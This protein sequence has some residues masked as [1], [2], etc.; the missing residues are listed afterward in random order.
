MQ[1]ITDSQLSDSIGQSGLT[2]EGNVNLSAE[3]L[4]YQ[5]RADSSYLIL[6]D[7]QAQFSYSPAT[8]D[9][10]AQGTIRY[11]LPNTLKFD[12]LSLALYSSNSQTLDLNNSDSIQ[13]YTIY[14]SSLGNQHK[15]FEL[16]I[17]GIKL[18]DGSN[19]FEDDYIDTNILEN[20]ASTSFTVN[21]KSDINIELISDDDCCFGNEDYAQITVVDEDG[22]IIQQTGSSGENDANLSLHFDSPI[23]NNFIVQATLTGTFNMGGA[24]EVF[25]ASNVPTKH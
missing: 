17:S 20:N 7:I 5:Q 2:I 22:N 19:Y 6:N 14:A 24:I 12:N 15:G 3:Q 8:V 11:G 10:T 18:D 13:T 25:T 1:E 4:S 23:N 16:N 21:S 9:I